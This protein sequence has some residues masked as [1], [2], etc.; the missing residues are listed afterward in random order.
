MRE[1]KFF[2]YGI[3]GVWNV[4][5]L[6]ANIKAII[7]RLFQIICALVAM[8]S[9]KIKDANGA[10]SHLNKGKLVSK[11]N[12]VIINV[13]AYGVLKILKASMRLILKMVVVNRNNY[14]ELVCAIKNGVKL[15]LK[16]IVIHAKSARIIR[17]VIFALTIS[18]PLPYSLN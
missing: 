17:V 11:V 4:N 16:E 9:S 8:V 6:H 5:V 18:N 12:F 1:I 3:I 2:I 13:M 10:G 7:K 15:Y 14:L